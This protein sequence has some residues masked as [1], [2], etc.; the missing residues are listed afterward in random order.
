MRLTKR[1]FRQGDASRQT[2]GNRPKKVVRAPL[3][4]EI[5]S[6]R[7]AAPF[8]TENS[9]HT[10][11]VL[12]EAHGGYL[13]RFEDVDVAWLQEVARLSLAEDR[14]EADDVGLQVTILAAP[15]LVRFAWDAPFTYGRQ[16]ARWYLTHHALARR[17]SEHLKTALHVYVFDPDELEQVIAYGNGRQVGGELLRYVDVEL[18]D[19]DEDDAAFEKLKNKW[20]MGH[21]ARVLGVAREELIR[22]PRQAT[23]L[24]D[25]AKQYQPQ[26]LWQ[27]VPEALRRGAPEKPAKEARRSKRR[28]VDE[29]ER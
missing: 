8:L 14:R 12:V 4:I 7:C 2:L 9:S 17:L 1:A 16:G 18:D 21:L 10:W 19:E 3:S 20:P 24:I 5:H 25:L 28:P 15:G 26:P 29:L 22:I 27:L 11:G 6:G 13:C 23:V